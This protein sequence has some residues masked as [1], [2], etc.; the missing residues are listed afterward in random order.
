GRVAVVTGAARGIGEAAAQALAAFGAEVAVCDRE[1]DDL[2][3]TRGDV[4]AV[5]R[6][7]VSA[8]LDV[9]DAE[10]VGGF[11]DEVRSTFGRVDIV[12][13]NAGGGFHAPFLDVSPKGQRAL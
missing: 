7:C 11:V 1:A 8:V 10:A 12:V 2:A 4:E 6:R 9:R 5:G 3:A 13:N